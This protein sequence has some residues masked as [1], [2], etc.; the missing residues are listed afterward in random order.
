[1]LLIVWVVFFDQHWMKLIDLGELL[2]VNLRYQDEPVKL[3]AEHESLV[4]MSWQAANLNACGQ[5]EEQ[6][7]LSP[8]RRW[9]I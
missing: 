3:L 4:D 5:Y 8:K 9:R 6:A 2:E 1:M 7:S